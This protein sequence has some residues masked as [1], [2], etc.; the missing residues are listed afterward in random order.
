MYNLKQYIMVCEMTEKAELLRSYV[1]RK[2]LH[3]GEDLQP[4]D[5][6]EIIIKANKSGKFK[7]TLYRMPYIWRLELLIDVFEGCG[8]CFPEEHKELTR[9]NVQEF[10]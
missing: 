1:Y 7:D 2:S 4:C 6:A 8:F 9:E 10:F 3:F 5:V